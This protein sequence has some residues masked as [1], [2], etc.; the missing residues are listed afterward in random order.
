MV[1]LLSVFLQSCCDDLRGVG[2]VATAVDVALQYSL[3]GGSLDGKEAG[4]VSG[5]WDQMACVEA[6]MMKELF[7]SLRDV[8]VPALMSVSSGG[9]FVVPKR[10]AIDHNQ[11]CREW[12]VHAR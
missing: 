5:Q 3:N 4:M 1:V 7:Q 10:E 2:K 9:D 12:E 8:G 11:N 6:E